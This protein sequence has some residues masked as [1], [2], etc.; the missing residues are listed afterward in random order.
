MD[1][2]TM[3]SGFI[4]SICFLRRNLSLYVNAEIIAISAL[5][6]PLSFFRL[7]RAIR[8]NAWFRDFRL[9]IA[10]LTSP[11][12]VFYGH[13]RI[14]K[15]N[16][17]F[18]AWKIRTMCVNGDE[19]LAK[20][21]ADHPEM[22]TEWEADRKLKKNPRVTWIGNILR[23]TSLDELPQLWNILQ[24]EMSLV[25]PRPIITDEISKYQ[26][27]FQHYLRA[28]P[29]VNG[30]WQISCRNLTTYEERVSYDTCY[31]QNWSPWFDLYILIRTI[32]V[33]LWREGAY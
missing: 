4:N 1:N 24:G 32:K 14:G 28:T 18:K 15:G 7:I 6:P 25:G 33:V 30:L 9:L 13:T 17:P 27:A 5:A 21:L 31:V 3:M 26:D 19:V 23:K 22:R 10:K 20:Y 11:G 29:G 12:Q 8:L 16:N 2:D